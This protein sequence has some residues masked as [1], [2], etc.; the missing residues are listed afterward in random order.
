MKLALP[1]RYPIFHSTG[2]FL[3]I[4]W[5]HIRRQIRSDPQIL[6]FSDPDPD[7]LQFGADPNSATKPLKHY[8]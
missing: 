8:N 3:A 2:S 1:I 7:W 5:K 4:L 6:D